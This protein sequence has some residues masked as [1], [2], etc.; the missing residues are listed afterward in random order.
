VVG[1]AGEVAEASDTAVVETV[2][3]V[4]LHAAPQTAA[5]IKGGAAEE[6]QNASRLA[7][8]ADAMSD[9]VGVQRPPAGPL[10]GQHCWPQAGRAK[11]RDPTLAVSLQHTAVGECAALTN[12]TIQKLLFNSIR[13]TLLLHIYAARDLLFAL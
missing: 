3:G 4:Q 6:A 13:Y 9:A 1:L 8:Y 12:Y 2:R 7:A 5:L 11:H 10:S